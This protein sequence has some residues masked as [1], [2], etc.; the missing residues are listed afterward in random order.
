M[1]DYDRNYALRGGV[2]TDRA[3]VVDEGLRAYML[4]VYNYMAMGVGTTGV[5]AW[6]AFQAAGGDAITR[7]PRGFTGITQFGQLILSFPGQIVLFVALLGIV[8]YTSARINRL[9]VGTAVTIFAVFS[10]LF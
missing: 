1:S 7:T 10:A 8:F 6:L 2:G 3:V 4:R 5:V 9:Q